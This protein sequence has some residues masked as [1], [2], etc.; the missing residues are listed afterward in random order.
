MWCREG[1]IKGAFFA[2]VVLV[3]LHF[4]HRVAKL[5]PIRFTQDEGI[6]T[7]SIDGFL[8]AMHGLKAAFDDNTRPTKLQGGSYFCLS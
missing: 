3:S 6:G 5:K 2:V 1:R 4:V 7:M 8:P